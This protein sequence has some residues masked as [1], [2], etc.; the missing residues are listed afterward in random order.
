MRAE[1][2][3]VHCTSYTICPAG[4][5]KDG[6]DSILAHQPNC[7]TATMSAWHAGGLRPWSD[8]AA[9][10]AAVASLPWPGLRFPLH[11]A[12][13]NW[14]IAQ[15]L[16]RKAY[17]SPGQAVASPRLGRHEAL[18]AFAGGSSTGCACRTAGTGAARFSRSRRATRLLSTP[19][20]TR[21]RTSRQALATSSPASA[22]ASPMVEKK[23]AKSRS[24]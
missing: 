18:G 23:Y 19:D 22:W 14:P 12:G 21:R 3:T 17:T 20:D 5:Q 4:L 2:E 9:G 10:W 16:A 11:L 6:W 1:L 15:F 24:S 8:S 7:P 13:T